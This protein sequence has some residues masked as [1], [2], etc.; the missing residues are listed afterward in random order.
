M[1]LK[2]HLRESQ[3]HVGLDG[4]GVGDPDVLH[5]PLGNRSL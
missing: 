2:R 5:E 1:R 4:G 3:S